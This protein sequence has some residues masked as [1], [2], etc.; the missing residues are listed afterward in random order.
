MPKVFSKVMFSD[1]ITLEGKSGIFIR[2]KTL[3]V[4]SKGFCFK[5]KVLVLV[6]LGYISAILN[7]MVLLLIKY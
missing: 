1:S 2:I 4:F 7:Y 6:R 5:R 3:L